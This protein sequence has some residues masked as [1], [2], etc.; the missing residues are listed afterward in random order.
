MADPAATSRW[1]RRFVLA[2]AFMFVLSQGMALARPASRAGSILGLNGFVFL[3]I[4]GKAYALIPAY[5]D[6]ELPTARFLPLHLFMTILG[7]LLLAAGI[8]WTHSVLELGGALLWL[9]GVGIF[10]GT[11]VATIRGNLTGSETGTGAANAHRQWVDRVANLFI[12]IAFGYLL[13]GSYELLAVSSALPPLFDGLATRATHLLA[14]GTGA[15]MVF[16][17][18]FRL[19]PRFLVARPPKVLVTIVLATG[20]VGPAL[21]AWGMPS[22]PIFRLG[23]FVQAIAIVGFAGAFVLLFLRSDRRRVGFYGVLSGAVAGIGAVGLG[24]AFATGY[25]VSGFE[26]AHRR[27]IL[28][29]FLGL[30]IVGI[31]YQ[32]YPPAVGTFRGSGD[33]TALVIIAALFLGLVIEV[34]GGV[35]GIDMLADAGRVIGLLGA[36]GHAYLL[37]GLFRERHG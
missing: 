29:G 33:R 28:V 18:G 3:T 26:L 22:G 27:L 15:G 32:F 34:S 4:F 14:A 1:V 23:A 6:S 30:T 11:F 13:V 31:S 24:I 16:A 37:G 21:L 35:N 8:E 17:V 20:A 19:L 2:G 5:F 7:T 10:L 12:P 25:P 36:L 9:A